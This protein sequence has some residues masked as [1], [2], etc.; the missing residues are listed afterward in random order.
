MVKQF[1]MRTQNGESIRM[2]VIDSMNDI[3]QTT[4]NTSTKLQPVN[5][6]DEI[7]QHLTRELSRPQDELFKEMI[8]RADS[9]LKKEKGIDIKLTASERELK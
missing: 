2:A 5:M 1:E 7:L 8:E 3:K 6:S 4:S 9:Y